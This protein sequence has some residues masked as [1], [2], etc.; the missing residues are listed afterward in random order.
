MVI[1]GFLADARVARLQSVEHKAHL[2]ECRQVV[3]TG[4]ADERKQRDL[5]GYSHSVSFS[6][7]L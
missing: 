6:L 2:G 3:T 1:T 5:E 7:P 4:G